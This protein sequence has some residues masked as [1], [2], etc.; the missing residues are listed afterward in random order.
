MPLVRRTRATF[1]SAELGFFG[2]VVY[3]RV[4]TPRFCGEP[5]RAGAACLARCFVRPRLTSW[6]MVGMRSGPRPSSCL[7]GRE[8][9]LFTQPGHE[10]QTPAGPPHSRA[11]HETTSGVAAGAGSSSV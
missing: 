10:C 2:V 3:T 9:E 4:H 5:C 1:R 8:N 11:P 7:H 6:L